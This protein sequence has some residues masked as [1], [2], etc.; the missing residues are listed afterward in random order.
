MT[1][2]PAAPAPTT[3]ARALVIGAT[4]RTGRHV[5]TGLLEHGITVRALARTP[6]TA[7]LPEEVEVGVGDLDDPASVAA[8]AKGADAAFLLWPSFAADVLS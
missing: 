5:V 2:T 3:P 4:G 6:M 1:T 7:D 8:A